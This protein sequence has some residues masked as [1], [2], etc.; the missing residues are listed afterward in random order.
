MN[1]KNDST[2]AYEFHK[3][4]IKMMGAEYDEAEGE[5]L[6]LIAQALQQKDEEAKAQRTALIEQIEMK[7]KRRSI[8]SGHSIDEYYCIECGTGVKT[9]PDE[10]F[11]YNEAVD[12]LNKKL[13]ELG[14]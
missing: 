14:E 13:Q 4:W 2:I 7:K 10:I 5:F 8:H 3:L 12:E 1:T 6:N 9:H 11:G